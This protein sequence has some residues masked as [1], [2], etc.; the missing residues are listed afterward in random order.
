MT[1]AMMLL[2]FWAALMAAEDTPLGR[3]LRRV[4]VEV[5]AKIASRV[6][7][8]HIALAIVVTMLVILHLNAGDND[9]I[10]MASLFAPEI[11][12]WLAGIE[13]SALIE[14]S[15][16]LLAVLAALRR[17]S[18]AAV[19]T[20]FFIPLRRHPKNMSNRARNGPRR[21]RTLPANDDDDGAEFALAS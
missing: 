9:P 16:G 4:M 19:L 20:A 21:D 17:V 14:A 7:P 5:P 12:V 2:M 8:G 3:F 6:E 11:T 18:V 10:R 15:I 1:A 13:I